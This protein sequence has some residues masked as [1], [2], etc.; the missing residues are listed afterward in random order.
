MSFCTPVR[1]PPAMWW[2]A[3][4]PAVRSPRQK[5]G[6]RPERRDDARCCVERWRWAGGPPAGHPANP[7][8]TR[9]GTVAHA[10]ERHQR[11]DAWRA[12]Q[13]E[14]LARLRDRL[15]Q[16]LGGESPT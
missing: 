10:E 14:R 6:R 13:R 1:R 8:D 2:L 9:P 15:K 5:A 12:K 11:F 16:A 3:A 7:W 4:A